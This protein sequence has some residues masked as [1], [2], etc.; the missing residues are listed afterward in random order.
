[1]PQTPQFVKEVINLR[2]KVIPVIE[3]RAHFDMAK[4]EYTERP[5]IIVVEIVDQAGMI[6]DRPR[7]RCDIG[8]IKH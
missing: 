7:R 5:C 1:M 8:G 4:I 2:G 6:S 3:L